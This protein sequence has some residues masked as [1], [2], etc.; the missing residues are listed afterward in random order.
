MITKINRVIMV[1]KDEYTDRM[2]SFSRSLE[3]NELIFH[4][5]GHVS[6]FFD[7]QILESTPNTIRFLPEGEFSRPDVMIRERSECIDVFF[8]A[9]RPISDK[10]FVIKASQSER[11]A[12][13]FITRNGNKNER[14]LGMVT[15]W[16]VLQ[17]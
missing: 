4:F 11:I 14:I 8:K 12:A 5:S 10:A 2:H 1:G 13:L 3:Y 15:P 16:D 9:D 7:G 17:E 6:V